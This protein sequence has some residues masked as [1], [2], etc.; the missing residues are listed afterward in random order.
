[1]AV[2][3]EAD[4]L[5]SYEEKICLIQI[6]TAAETYIV[7]PFTCAGALP[8]LGELLADRRLLKV[9]HGGDYDI[10]LLKKEHGFE[11]AGIF[12][13]MVAAQFSSRERFGLAPLLEEEFKVVLDKRFQRADWSQRPLPEDMLRYAALDT[14]HLLDLKVRLE[15]DLRLLGRTEWVRE[16]FGLLEKVEPAA[17]KGPTAYGIKGAGRLSPE[18]RGRLQRLLDIRDDAARKLDRPP[19]KVISN[20]LLLQLSSAPPGTQE[21]VS[22]LGGVSRR[23]LARLSSRIWQALSLP[24]REDELL[25]A[26]GRGNVPLSSDQKKTLRS[27]KKARSWLEQKLALPPGLVCNSATLEKLCRMETGDAL[28]YIQTEFKGWQRAV[29]GE[30]FSGV[31]ESPGSSPGGS[32]I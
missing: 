27:L 21:E 22:R 20:G 25:P 30:L 32:F 4:S 26:L 15:E 19:F 10:R 18:G 12:D 17:E 1:M 7:D 28:Q 6:S 13:T 16:E 3:L 24:L 31:L 5:H 23:I 14:A 9:F 29:A 8:L 11:I 2:D